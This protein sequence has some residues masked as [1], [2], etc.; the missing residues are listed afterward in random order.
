M[1][2][3]LICGHTNEKRI[4]SHVLLRH[5]LTTKEYKDRFNGAP[6]RVNEMK[7]LRDLRRY[8]Q[9]NVHPDLWL[10]RGNG[11][12][13]FYSDN[14]ELALYLATLSQTSVYVNNW[15]ELS[16]EVWV[17]EAKEIIEKFNPVK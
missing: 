13:Y 4:D 15:Q 5:W 16:P 11:Y 9:K 10:A 1:I 8:L 6:T 2:K 14:E 3:C 17:T 12:Y 7:T